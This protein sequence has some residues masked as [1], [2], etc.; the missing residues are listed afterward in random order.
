[1]GYTAVM[2][3]SASMRKEPCATCLVWR[4]ALA[5]T[6]LALLFGWLSA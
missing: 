4:A 2:D 5:V 6:A 3:K 1:M